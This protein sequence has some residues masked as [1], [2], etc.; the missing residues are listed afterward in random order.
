MRTKTGYRHRNPCLAPFFSL[1]LLGA[2]Q[3]SYNKEYMTLS[4]FRGFTLF[5][6]WPLF[7]SLFHIPFRISV[8]KNKSYR[9]RDTQLIVWPS[10]CRHASCPCRLPFNRC[11]APSPPPVYRH[12]L[13][14][15]ICKNPTSNPISF[16]SHFPFWSGCIQVIFVT[17]L[18]IFWDM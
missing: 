2:L 10:L 4:K 17:L 3:R 16:E 1:H 7:T 12:C 11:K 18:D 8:L 15:S 5:V 13:V 9:P 14:F 6:F